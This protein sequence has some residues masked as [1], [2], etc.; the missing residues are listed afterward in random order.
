MLPWAEV[1]CKERDVLIV[2]LKRTWVLFWSICTCK[3]RIPYAYKHLYI[4]IQCVLH[5]CISV[6]P[7][8]V[9]WKRFYEPGVKQTVASD[10]GE[11]GS[12]KLWQ[13][14]IWQIWNY[15][16]C[17]DDLMHYAYQD[18]QLVSGFKIPIWASEWWNP[19]CGV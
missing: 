13:R 1:S 4:T 5:I 9:M 7:V 16:H 18:E 12:D 17:R 6:E 8:I 2:Y 3:W 11:D 15:L 19:W 14:W 10:N